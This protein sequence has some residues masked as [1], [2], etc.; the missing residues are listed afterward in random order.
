MNKIY[1]SSLT[2]AYQ[3]I[4]F[5]RQLSEIDNDEV[6]LFLWQNDNCVVIGRNQNPLAECNMDYLQ[7]NEIVLARRYSGGGAVFHDLGNVNYTLVMKEKNYSLEKAKYFLLKAF[8]YLDLDVEFSGRNDMTINGAKFSGQAYYAHSSNY[9]LHGTLML[10]LK[11]ATL[12]KC[13]TPSKKKLESK[14][15]KSVKSRVVNLK[16]VDSDL[17]VAGIKKALVRAFNVV[18]GEAGETINVTSKH[19]DSNLSNYIQSDEWLYSQSPKYNL[20]I[21][22]RFPFG[23]VTLNLE[24]K[25]NKIAKAKFYTDSL[26]VSWDDIE[27]SLVGL[28]YNEEHIWDIIGKHAK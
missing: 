11:I 20:E 12:G 10:D 19:I 3:N 9:V 16:Q 2:N 1:D 26:N 4:A 5:E 8:E 15:I 7:E 13:L 18:Y 27:L 17:S 14:G 24:V 28:T 25:N 6:T 21:D 22:K 23:N